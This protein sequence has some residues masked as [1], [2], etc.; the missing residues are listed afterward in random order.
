MT[1]CFRFRDDQ[2]YCLLLQACL[3]LCI[4]GASKQLPDAMAFLEDNCSR[5]RAGFPCS[6]LMLPSLRADDAVPPAAGGNIILWCVASLDLD[7]CGI[8]TRSFIGSAVTP[9][10]EP[11][12]QG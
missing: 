3:Q 1:R 5:L 12:P 4:K 10:S 11:L 8:L 9:K 2:T 6:R 7:S